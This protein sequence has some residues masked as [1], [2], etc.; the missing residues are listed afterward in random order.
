MKVFRAH[1]N[2]KLPVK[3]KPGSRGWD[4]CCISDFI[5]VPGMIQTI[6]TGLIIQPPAGTTLEIHARS[7]LAVRGVGLVNGVGTIDASF[8]GPNDVL[9]VILYNQ[10]EHEIWFKAGDRIAQFVLVYDLDSIVEEVY[11]PPSLINRG[12]LGS[13]GLS[14]DLL[15]DEFLT[16]E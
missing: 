11:V 1:P 3:S 2:A 5:L 15:V 7:G 9:S 8:C 14:D 4:I 16:H 6:S 12:G 10:G 13:T